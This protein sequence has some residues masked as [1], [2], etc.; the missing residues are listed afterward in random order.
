M[1]QAPLDSQDLQEELAHPAQLVH[2]ENPDPLDLLGKRV[3]LVFVETTDPLEDKER[4]DQQDHPAAQETKETL[5]KTD[6]RVLMVLQAQLE[7]Q[8][9][10]ALWVFLVREESA[11]CQ[12]FQDQRDHQENRDLQVNLETKD[13]QVQSVFLVLMDLV[14]ILVLMALQDLMAHQAKMVFLDKEETE[15]TL[16]QKVWLVHRDS[17]ALQVLLVQRVVLEGEETLAQEDLLAHLAQL[18]RED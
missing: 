13:P 17:L 8:D 3:L 10:E 18:E 12:A 16:V 7:L 9:R 15:E 11:G 1:H 14:V 2:W 4:E 5:E 6:P